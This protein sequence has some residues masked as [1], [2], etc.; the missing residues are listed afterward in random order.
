MGPSNLWERKSKLMYQKTTFGRFWPI[1]RQIGTF[2]PL[3]GQFCRK[4]TNFVGGI[5]FQLEKV[6]PTSPDQ[7]FSI[8]RHPRVQ[9][10]RLTRFPPAF[11]PCLRAAVG[12]R[13][14]FWTQKILIWRFWPVN[15]SI[16]SGHVTVYYWNHE[17][18]ISW[19]RSEHFRNF[20]TRSERFRSFVKKQKYVRKVLR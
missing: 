1:L 13:Q 11:S 5:G 18:T 10:C 4:I 8:F 2:L 14:S 20:F 3:W 19:S 6:I 17:S 16:V 9:T 15:G 12:F 7:I